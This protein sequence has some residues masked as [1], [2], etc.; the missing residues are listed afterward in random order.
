MNELEKRIFAPS[1]SFEQKAL[2]VYRYQIQNNAIYQRFCSA[3]R[4]PDT[5]DDINEIPLL[6]IEAFKDATVKTGS[7]ENPELLFQ[8]SGTSGMSRSRHYVRSAELYRQSI[9]Q[10]FRNFYDLDQFIFWGYTPG[11]AQNPHSSLIW[12][13]NELIRY[14]SSQ[15]SRFLPLQKPLNRKDSKEIR[16]SGKQLMIFG[17]AFGLIDL[18]KISDVR[19]PENTII[20]ETGGM[21]T[22]KREMSRQELHQ[23]LSAGF[24]LPLQNIHSEYGMTEL[25]SQAYAR[26]TEWFETPPWSKITIHDPENPMRIQVD[27]EEGLIGI[28]DLANLYSCSFLLTGDAGVRRKDGSFQVLGRWKKTNLRGCNFLIDQD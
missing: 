4:V 20:M 28:M 12:M 2:E 25:L 9:Q 23:K 17:A 21:K 22:Y 6:S 26:G 27:G 13:I 15:L 19:L 16:D 1:L 5:L 24:G 8:S 18:V 14:D 11:Y 10:G 7:W 3:L